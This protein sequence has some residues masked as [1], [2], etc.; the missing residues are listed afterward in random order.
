[1]L[2]DYGVAK[3]WPPEAV[4]KWQRHQTYGIPKDRFERDKR[5][6]ETPLPLPMK[7][8]IEV[9]ISGSVCSSNLG[10]S[11]RKHINKASTPPPNYLPSDSLINHIISFHDK[12]AIELCQP[13]NDALVITLSI[14]NCQV[15]RI[16]VNNGN[17]ADILFLTTLKEMDI[18]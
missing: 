7:K 10:S 4:L 12:E 3:A 8:T 16:F 1:M 9:I 17:S 14:T 5:P 15:G 2:R 18:S 6:S 13:H 11:I